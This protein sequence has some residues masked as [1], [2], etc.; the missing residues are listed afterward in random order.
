MSQTITK[1]RVRH[2]KGVKDITLVFK[3]ITEITGPAGSGKSSFIDGLL[4][5]L[6]G[7]T[8]WRNRGFDK[9]P[10]HNEAEDAEVIVNT[11]DYE[12]RAKLRRDKDGYRHEVTIAHSD[13]GRYGSSKLADLF[14]QRPDP[15]EFFTL[16]KEKIAEVLQ[17]FIPQETQIQI[18]KLEG[19]IKDTEEDRLVLTR[20]L[21]KLGEPI[22][23]PE[24]QKVSV[25]ELYGCR[26][27]ILKY[28][29][30]QDAKQRAIDL[31]TADIASAK[32]RIS[33]IE[34]QIR[35]LEIRKATE[36]S[37]LSD[38][39]AALEAMP[40]P[41]PHQDTT[42]IDRLIADA[43]K[44]IA[45][46]E[47]WQA[48]QKLVEEYRDLK[49]RRQKADDSIKSMREEREKLLASAE[50]PIPDVSIVGTDV[51]VAGKP[52]DQLSTSEQ[53]VFGTKLAVANSANE[54]E[55]RIKTL[56]IRH[57]EALDDPTFKTIS[58]IATEAG[59]SLIIETAREGHSDEAIMIESGLLKDAEPQA[60]P[61]DA[62][63][64]KGKKKA[65][66]FTAAVK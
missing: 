32:K 31:Q 51:F 53:Y 7:K 21:S 62:P 22:S 19:R 24:V 57:G 9:S 63:K 1:A 5:A 27:D 16:P 28:N 2:V 3:P 47:A 25:A 40:G 39:E 13:G 4:I 65:A 35:N 34:E 14:E 61:E 12:F 58:D 64:A 6:L 48:N 43:D 37:N 54:N 18:R 36:V 8:A 59:Y 20:Q 17:S 55:D 42:D 30:E 29:R 66:G 50:M 44:S 60:A 26:D 56:F 10:I 11:Q 49:D 33:D 45:A 38:L 52:V 23:L 41:E 46:Y 15:T